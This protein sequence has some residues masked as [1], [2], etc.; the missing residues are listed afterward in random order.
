MALAKKGMF[1]TLMAMS[2]ITLMLVA[3]TGTHQ[4]VNIKAFDVAESE[5]TILHLYKSTT[6]N[7]AKHVLH[8]QSVHAVEAM[9][10]YLEN[11]GD[12]SDTQNAFEELVTHATIDGSDAPKMGGN[13][14]NALSNDI[15]D[16][17]ARFLGIQADIDIVN[18]RI[19]Q[20]NPWEVATYADIII[21][22][23]KGNL[24]YDSRRTV[25]S[26]FAITEYE[27]P[28]YLRY[29][30]TNYIKTSRRYDYNMSATY[31][32][33][34]NRTYRHV[35]LAPSFIMRIEENYDESACCGIESLINSTMITT[36]AHE[37]RSW[38]DHLFWSGERSCTNGYHPL[39]NFTWLSEQSESLGFK[40]DS[41]YMNIYGLNMS[42]TWNYPP[43]DPY[44]DP[45]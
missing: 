31:D 43:A 24:S 26:T 37:E 28:L 8:M 21:N 30:Y 1:F 11:G 42:D 14:L 3:F 45:K 15:E 12:I 23:T 29:G 27:D 20:H 13:T 44:C 10:E 40:L 34:I 17:G 39:Y 33:L 16:E 9:L 41:E 2:I 22:A 4:L 7:Y 25:N 5:Y 18:P 35:E 38:V 6:E 36:A 32:M 19:T